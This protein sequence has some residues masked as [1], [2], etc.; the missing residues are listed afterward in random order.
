MKTITDYRF[1]KLKIKEGDYITFKLNFEEVYTRKVQS[2]H[3]Q[4]FNGITNYNVNRIGSG[5]GVTGVDPQW[6]IDIKRV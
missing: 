4:S 3:I 1:D 6:I 2:M 5:S